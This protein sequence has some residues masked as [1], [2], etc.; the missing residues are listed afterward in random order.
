MSLDRATPRDLL[1]L[2]QSLI[3]ILEIIDLIK[4]NDNI[5]LKDILK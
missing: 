5:K 2:K 3:S 4:N 1:N